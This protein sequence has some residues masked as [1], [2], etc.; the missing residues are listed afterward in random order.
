MIRHASAVEE[1]ADVLGIARLVCQGVW[2]DLAD[3]CAQAAED[4][5]A[6]QRGLRRGVGVAG[7]AADPRWNGDTALEDLERDYR[8][9]F[10]Q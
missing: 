7:A 6:S 10:L 2:T 3:R 9:A 4:G 8:V 1:A 5:R